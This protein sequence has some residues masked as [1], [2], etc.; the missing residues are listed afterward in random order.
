MGDHEELLNQLRSG[1]VELERE[2]AFAAGE[3]KVEE[4]VPLLARLVQ[5]Q[6]LGV[7]EAAD[8]AL[9]RIGGPAVVRAVAPLL[10]SD[11]PPS[12]NIAMDVMREVGDQDFP[13][14]IDLLHDDDP[15]M[16]IFSSDILGSTGNLMAVSALCEALLKDPEVNVRYQ[17]AVSLG[18]LG[19]P[20]AAKCLNK[21][22]SDDEWSS[23]R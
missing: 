2:A 13:T 15:D 4:A 8:R 6:N 11:D 14:L 17:A 3:G 16:R 10:R 7:Q 21:A 22:L 5:S 12:R 9:R 23:S 18:A 19:R 20:E 1:D